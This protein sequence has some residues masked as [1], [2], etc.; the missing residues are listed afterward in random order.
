MVLI[1]WLR[2]AGLCLLLVPASLLAADTPDPAQLISVLGSDAAS[3]SITPGSYTVEPVNGTAVLQTVEGTVCT[4]TSSNRYQAPAEYLFT[5]RLA[6]KTGQTAIFSCRVGVTTLPDQRPQSFGFSVAVAGGNE[7]LWY[8]RTIEPPIAPAFGSTFSLR[9]IANRSL[10]WPES[11]RKTIEAQLATPPPLAEM[12]QTVRLVIADGKFTSFYNER[13]AD[14]IVLTND[15]DRRGTI[16]V[17]LYHPAQLLSVRVK[18]A[19]NVGPNFEPLG[20]GGLFNA[21]AIVRGQRITDRPLAAPG[22][23]VMLDGVPF[24]FPEPDADGNDHL[25]LEPSWA[26]FGSLPGFFMAHGGPFGG[27]WASADR[28]DPFRF[29]THVPKGQY[30][31]LH[32]IAVADGENN[33]VPVVT[34]QFFRSGAGH[35]VNFSGD[36]PPFT[37]GSADAKGF[38]VKLANGK[39]GRLHHVVI[40]LEPDAFAWFTDRPRI[41]MELTKQVQPYR[42]YPDPLEYSWHGAGLPSGVHIYAATLERAPV[43]VDP[44]P[45]QVSHVWTAPATPSYTI[46][47]RN[48]SGA[49]TS[50]T[51]TVTSTSYDGRETAPPQEKIVTLPAADV[52]V[53]VPV[54]LSLQRYGLHYLTVSCAVA[55]QTYTYRR[56][57]AYLHADTRERGNWAEGKGALF[58]YNGWGGGHETPDA[59]VDITVMGQAGAETSL[60]SYGTNP[61]PAIRELA[62]KYHIIQEEA[63]EGWAMYNTA[64]SAAYGAELPALFNPEDPEGTGKILIERLK[65]IKHTPGPLNHP[66]YLPFFPEPIVAERLVSGIFPRHYNAPLY[67]FTEGDEALYQH[68]LTRFLIGAPA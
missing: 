3:W 60:A 33:S 36:V 23:T 26:A 40:P 54:S 62:A 22:Q 29:Q 6:P 68:Y 41:A 56:N 43:A 45:D 53:P 8:N 18:P 7:Y 24:R 50:A 27:R 47:V 13:F 46:H 44:R 64:F 32:L 19:R 34:A 35:P 12:L 15:F 21:A 39:K 14:Q 4:L 31:A 2:R 16:S 48:R 63:F 65:P 66:T 28:I 30:R 9:A 52:D 51:L 55:G 10:A 59:S 58:G 42:G 11:I 49:A 17:T 20:I 1:P 57:L 38:P 25:D 37:G 67:Q 61:D 5:F